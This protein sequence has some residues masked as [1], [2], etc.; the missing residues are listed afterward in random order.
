MQ[1]YDL[2]STQDKED[3]YNWISNIGFEGNAEPQ[4]LQK[5]LSYWNNAKS[6]WLFKAF[7]DKLKIEF[8]VEVE[9]TEYALINNLEKIFS[10]IGLNLREVYG[11]ESSNIKSE[12]IDLL[13]R[14]ITEECDMEWTSKR[15]IQ[16]MFLYNNFIAGHLEQDYLIDGNGKELKLKQGTKIMKALNKLNNFLDFPF[17]CDF[18]IFRNKISNISTVRN[19][20]GT[21]VLSIHPIDYM[22]MSDNNCDWTSCMSWHTGS[23][24]GGTLE[25]MNS[26]CAVVG[27]LK[28]DTEFS[29]AYPT[30]DNKQWRSLYY[31]TEDILFSGKPYPYECKDLTLAGLDKLA[32]LV[33]N[34]LNWDYEMTCPY[35]DVTLTFI[36]DSDDV[37][38]GT[39]DCDMTLDPYG[40][41]LPY[42]YGMYNDMVADMD[43]NYYCYRNPVEGC[44]LLCISGRA[45]CM[46]CGELMDP[47]Y[48]EGSEEYNNLEEQE[49]ESHGACVNCDDCIKKGRIS[50][51]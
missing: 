13:A 28:S 5:S 3:I 32:E 24:C 12:Y 35:E 45:N 29:K 46:L 15:S 16:T 19:I 4:D 41:I 9:M 6:K 2:L 17:E 30:I 27:Y 23:Y 8:P 10:P 34:N 38:R 1:P 50:F 51:E 25:M 20:K 33:Y 14:W 48:P 36:R 18:E 11:H 26:D 21:F 44:K 31:V 43:T 22:T 49:Y 37:R 42:T 39:F 7:G 47:Q 40:L